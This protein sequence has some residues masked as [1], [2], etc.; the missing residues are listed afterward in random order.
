MLNL[1]SLNALVGK[2][3]QFTK[4]IEDTEWYAEDKMRGTIT[5]VHVQDSD[6]LDPVIKFGVSFA[7]FDEYN[8]RFESSNYYDN[9]G[10]PCLTARESNFYE[11]E[12]SVYLGRDYA[13]CFT[14]LDTGT[15]ALLRM[16]ATDK[17]SQPNISYVEW[18]ETLALNAMPYL[19][20]PANNA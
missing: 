12:D 14:V 19:R 18:L 7:K 8:K 5:S 15:E 20:G 16:F 6:P 2:D 11:V 10:N 13:E 1:D 17:A 3:V 9:S 4:K